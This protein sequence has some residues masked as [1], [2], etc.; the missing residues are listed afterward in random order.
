MSS[1]SR[2]QRIRPLASLTERTVQDQPHLFT[3]GNKTR[4]FTSESPTLSKLRR[5][6][7]GWWRN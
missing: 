7:S 4:T 5:R 3:D 1:V 2:K 6:R